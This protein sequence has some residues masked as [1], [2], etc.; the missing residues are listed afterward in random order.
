MRLECNAIAMQR[1]CNAMQCGG[2]RRSEEGRGRDEGRGSGR[3]EGE[4]GLIPT[5]RHSSSPPA[6]RSSSILLS[7]CPPPPPRWQFNAMPCNATQCNATQCKAMQCGGGRR[8]EDGG[9]RRGRG[10]EGICKL[11]SRNGCLPSPSPSGYIKGS[12]VRCKPV[13]G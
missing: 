12:A 8:S 11:H 10:V 1:D 4:E 6:S 3:E 13:N 2:G 5:P 7:T 9:G